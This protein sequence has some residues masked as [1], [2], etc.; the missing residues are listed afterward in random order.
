VGRRELAG[1]EERPTVQQE[2]SEEVGRREKG[3]SLWL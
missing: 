3:E 1:S 2:L